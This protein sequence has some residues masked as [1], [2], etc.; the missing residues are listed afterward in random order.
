MLKKVGDIK[1]SW[2]KYDTVLSVFLIFEFA[3]IY[4]FEAQQLPP[5]LTKEL[6]VCSLP[7]LSS[8]GCGGGGGRYLL[9]HMVFGFVLLLL[10]FFH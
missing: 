2:G 10:L 8:F 1:C 5:H 7:F 3:F 6:L 4:V 9:V